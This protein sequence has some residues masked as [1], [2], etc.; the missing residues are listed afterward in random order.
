MS[1]AELGQYFYAIT[2][3]KNFED[4]TG[5]ERLNSITVLLQVG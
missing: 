1:I 2:H 5:G 4:S 3:S